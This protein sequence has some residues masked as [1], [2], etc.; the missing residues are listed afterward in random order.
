MAG[1][2]EEC[3]QRR[4]WWGAEATKCAECEWETRWGLEG[5]EQVEEDRA[6]VETLGQWQRGSAASAD[7]WVFLDGSGRVQA[8]RGGTGR[9]DGVLEE[10]LW[11][12]WQ[13]QRQGLSHPNSRFMEPLGQCLTQPDPVTM[14]IQPTRRAG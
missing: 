10:H 1:G 12:G 8:P 14:E 9:P 7:T 2:C 4:W 6:L 13:G 5:L 11:K 3:A